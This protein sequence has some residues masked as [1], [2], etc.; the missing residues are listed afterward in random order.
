MQASQKPVIVSVV[1]AAVV[2][3][4]L[5][6]FGVSSMNSN[7]K[8][9]NENLEGL[10]V[11]EVAMVSSIANAFIAGIT[12]P[13]MPE[14]DTE[15]LDNL[16]DAEYSG[17]IEIL[18]DDAEIVAIEQFVEDNEGFNGTYFFEDDEI[19]DL[20]TEN[21]ECDGDCKVEYIKEYDDREVEVI[22][23]GLNDL[24]ERLIELSTV[25]RVKVFTDEDDSDEYFFDKVTVSSTVTSE[26]E[27]LEAE[28]IYSL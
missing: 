7:L 24:D 16:W 23:L 21:V 9:L 1:I 3:L 11:D 4:I 22:N 5:G 10:D 13:K 26:D 12:M 18:E 2:L 8:T 25:I 19:F 6:A 15:K 14:F 27:E 17:I 28:V 20:V